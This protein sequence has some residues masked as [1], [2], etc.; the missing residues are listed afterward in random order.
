MRGERGCWVSAN[1]YSCAHRARINFEDLTPYLTYGYKAWRWCLRIFGCFK[2]KSGST[3]LAERNKG[4]SFAA[5]RSHHGWI[6][7]GGQ[8][9][10]GEHPGLSLILG[11]F[12]RLF[13]FFFLISLRVSSIYPGFSGLLQG[14]LDLSRVSWTS[15]EC[16]GFLPWI[17]A[18]FPELPQGFLDF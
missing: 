10:E 6:G 5:G 14:V 4:K 3:A 18:G 8:G 9:F 13:R 7:A 2:I 11:F 12:P 1:E 16:L 17:S 15:P